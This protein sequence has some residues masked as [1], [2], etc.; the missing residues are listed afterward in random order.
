[1]PLPSAQ[2]ATRSTTAAE[3]AS[4]RAG[5]RTKKECRARQKEKAAA[6]NPAATRTG[7]ELDRKDLTRPAMRNRKLEPCST[8]NGSVTK[9][10]FT[11]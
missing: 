11:N 4:A 3:P 10:Q 7:G 8:S 6:A 9:H 2:D 5:L 1:M